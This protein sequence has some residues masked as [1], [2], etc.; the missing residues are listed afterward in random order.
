MIYDGRLLGLSVF[1]YTNLVDFFV[2][3][4]NREMEIL[5]EQK[6]LA[7]YFADCLLEARYV[8]GLDEAGY[9]TIRQDLID[10]IN[11]EI[12]QVIFDNITA[13]QLEE[14]E[15]LLDDED[16]EQLAVFLREAIPDLRQLILRRL[17]EI[18]NEV[19][20]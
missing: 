20:I 18:K 14:M 8:A 19:I 3:C 6:E 15:S 12:S 13:A 16:M 4:Y 10:R 17:L 7:G 11:R 5:N 9:E 1:L 2:V